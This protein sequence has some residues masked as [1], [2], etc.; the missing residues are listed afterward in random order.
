MYVSV[1]HL[2]K[3]IS[4]LTRN[5][6][7]ILKQQIIDRK[8]VFHIF[9]WMEVPV[10]QWSQYSLHRI[11]PRDVIGWP[12]WSEYVENLLK[13]DLPVIARNMLVYALRLGRGG[14]CRPS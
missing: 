2:S 8:F 1:A 3:T 14:Q 10:G 11:D 13:G 6:Q 7:H 12:H 5:Q 9:S 4:N